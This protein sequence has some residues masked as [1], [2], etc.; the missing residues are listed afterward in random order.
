MVVIKWLQ[1]V[2]FINL[3]TATVEA[4]FLHAELYPTLQTFPPSDISLQSPVLWNYC[5]FPSHFEDQKRQNTY[6]K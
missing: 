4:L 1:E 6:N 3:S 5:I 2:P